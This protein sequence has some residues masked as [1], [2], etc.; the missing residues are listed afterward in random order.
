[1]TLPERIYTHGGIFHAD[2]MVA[3]ATIEAF[4]GIKLEVIRVFQASAEALA[5]SKF[6][7]LDI[8]GEYAPALGNFDHHHDTNSPATNILI[9]RHVCTDLALCEVLEKNF[10]TAISNHDRGIA[11]SEHGFN[12]TVRA[13]N[14]LGKTGDY[15]VFDRAYGF[16]L[17]AVKAQIATARAY[18]ASKEAW[19][20]LQVRGRVA[21]QEEGEQLTGWRDFAVVDGIDYLATPNVRGGWQVISIDS[22]THPIPPHP[23]QTFRHASGFMA[24]YGTK[25]EAIRHAVL[26]TPNIMLRGEA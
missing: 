1:M 14:S 5:S 24:V 9:L 4:S 16:V 6:W 26:L 8:G 19:N 10:Y 13:F 22:N 21:I 23:S 11:M 18:L 12:A 2:E 25:E 17:E 20:N 15:E 3:I 7:V